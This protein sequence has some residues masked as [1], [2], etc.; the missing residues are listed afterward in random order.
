MIVKIFV[1]LHKKS[2]KI[3]EEDDWNEIY[4][5][6]QFIEIIELSRNYYK[7][8]SFGKN[9]LDDTVSENSILYLQELIAENYP[10]NLS[11]KNHE[12]NNY[13]IYLENKLKFLRNLQYLEN[14]IKTNINL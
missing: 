2:K 7:I 1:D 11:L 10:F 3:Y 4:D 8:I 6:K 12:E 9:Y 14:L 5:L 13:F